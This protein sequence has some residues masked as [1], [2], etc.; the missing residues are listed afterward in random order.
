M[1]RPP[2]ALAGLIDA[3]GDHSLAAVARWLLAAAEAERVAANPL[4]QQM[5]TGRG[6]PC[7]PL[8][9]AGVGTALTAEQAVAALAAGWDEPPEPLAKVLA[10]RRP[11]WLAEFVQL[12]HRRAPQ[13][14]GPVI[15]LVLEA[16]LIRQPPGPYRVTETATGR[17]AEQ[18][19][20]LV[21]LELAELLPDRVE[22]AAVRTAARMGRVP[23]V[24][25]L[26]PM[27]SVPLPAPITDPDELVE[28]FANL[29]EADG[30]PVLVQ[31]VLAGAVRTAGLPPRV[32][33]ARMA[34]LLDRAWARSVPHADTA[35]RHPSWSY[36]AALAFGWGTGTG[37]RL[38][39][40]H[41][42]PR[43]AGTGA[44]ISSPDYLPPSRLS[45][46]FG[47][48][49]AECTRLIAT[50]LG[51]QLLAE[52]THLCGG[53][54]PEAMLRRLQELPDGSAGWLA[55]TAPLDLE[56]AALRLPRDL[57]RSFWRAARG[58]SPPIAGRLWQHYAEQR[59]PLLRPVI[60]VPSGTYLYQRDRGRPIALAEIGD[61]LPHTDRSGIWSV[62]TNLQDAIGR[63]EQLMGTFGFFEYDQQAAMWSMIAPWHHELLSTH[64]LM[65]LARV[66][67]GNS[68]APSA[69]TVLDSPTG[70]FGPIA[71][72]ALVVALQAGAAETRAV[73]AETWLATAGDGRLQ[74]AR[75]AEALVLLARNKVLRLGRLLETV[76]PSTYE[77]ATGYR[78]LQV[79]AAALPELLPLQPPELIEA[80]DLL[81]EL[82]GRYGT[83]LIPDELRRLAGSRSR[84]EL[85]KAARRVVSAD[86][87]A[88][89]RPLAVEAVLEGLIG[90][91]SG[92]TYSYMNI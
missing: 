73:A 66:Q 68:A 26:S 92:L 10:A 91:L 50:G 89:D 9:L 81:A 53:I 22:L 72:L 41:F 25:E 57:D 37:W 12:W 48:Q 31:R 34:P 75:L 38:D 84:G 28:L 46:V 85:A 87:R 47:L 44:W 86:D 59:Q 62:L 1:S 74:P 13:P 32:R 54:E 43:G 27:L 52:P 63:F 15:E 14:A 82:A 76:R 60:G 55:R 42:E 83:E 16:G 8:R 69:A 6:V 88:A 67:A 23:D 39:Y 65:P 61:G 11:H 71:H 2:E 90:R 4:V 5:L 51:Q 19:E 56:L 64:V 78:T 33:A 58:A 36:L 29:I 24:A 49:V 77:P 3:A 80:I 7:P 18:L 45:G 30:N 21:T 35:G 40:R 79:L 20:R 70:S 17:V